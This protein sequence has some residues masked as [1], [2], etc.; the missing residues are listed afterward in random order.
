L[1]QKDLVAI[2]SKELS[3]KELVAENIALFNRTAKEK[4]ITLGSDISASKVKSDRHVLSTVLRN[5]L[6]N[7]IKYTSEG[8]VINIIASDK[9]GRVVLSVEDSG[10]GMSPGQ[11]D[12]L[13]TLDKGKTTRGTSGERGTGLGMHLVQQLVEKIEGSIEISSQLGTG[14]SFTVQFPLNT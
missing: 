9:D 13:F 6:D 2:D 10:V 14:S 4:G 3:L 8:G 11:I 1:L 12:K 5:L 7:A